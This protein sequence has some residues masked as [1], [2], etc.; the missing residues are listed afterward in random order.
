MTNNIVS[1]FSNNF[2]TTTEI[3][4]QLISN[5]KENYIT[6]QVVLQV[7]LA[8]IQTIKK[9]LDVGKLPTIQIKIGGEWKLFWN[10]EAILQT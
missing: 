9:T 5:F 8:T 1:Y 2:F 4:S 10:S 3:T 6:Q 7:L